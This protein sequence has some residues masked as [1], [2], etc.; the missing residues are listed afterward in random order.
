[1]TLHAMADSLAVSLAQKARKLA[2]DRAAPPRQ[3]EPDLP[4]FEFTHRFET[5][6]DM[7]GQLEPAWQRLVATAIEPNSF[8]EPW[9]LLPAWCSLAQDERVE[10]LVIEAPKRVHPEGPKVICGLFPIIR[11]RSFYGLPIRCWEL[12]RHPHCFLGT[13][14]VRRDC[15]G[16]VLD[17]FFTAAATSPE[18]AAVVHLP[19]IAGDG[20]LQ[21]ALIESNYAAR[22][23]VFTKDLQTRALFRRAADAESFLKTS[24]SRKK[25]QSI[26]RTERRL[27]ETGTLTTSWYRDHDDVDAWV[28][29]FL[30]LEAG[31]WKGDSQTALDSDERHSRFFR[32]MLHGG[33]MADKLLL[34]RL[35]FD[36]RPIAMICNFMTGDGGY[37]FKIAYDE[38]FAEHSPGLLLELALIRELHE[39]GIEWMDSCAVPDHPMINPLWPERTI[40]QSLVV[41][42]GA[43]YGDLAVSLMPLVRWV[44]SKL[45]RGKHRE[46]AGGRAASKTNSQH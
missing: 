46:T 6:P 15:V 32:D 43:R 18:G 35:D 26:Q 27:A 2:T 20:P 31:G 22:R 23:P 44:K 45:S 11:R 16:E 30:R 19:M 42:T 25:R 9:F 1:M 21:R 39:R 10:L 14:L 17:Y 3:D 33:A 37:S 28:D 12:W 13:P 24:L 38:K 34:G 5:Q 40:R 4:L 7:L 29:A 41:S 8:F 36:G